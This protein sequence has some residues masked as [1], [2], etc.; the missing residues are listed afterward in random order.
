MGGIAVAVF[1]L[2]RCL[3]WGTL[4]LGLLGALVAS[5][6]ES[7]PD[8]ALFMPKPTVVASIK[9]LALLAQSIAGQDLKVVTL[10]PPNANPHA[11]AMTISD[12]QLLADASLV[13]WLGPHFERFLTKPMAQRREPQL[14]LGQ[15]AQLNWP[16]EPHQDLHLWL[17]PHNIAVALRALTRELVALE[18]LKQ[19]V[20]ERRLNKQLAILEQTA[21]DIRVQLAP[22]RDAPFAV[23]HDGYGHFV[24]AFNLTQLAAATR[25]PEQQLS[26]RR[27]YELQ[28]SLTDARCLIV[29]LNDAAGKKLARVVKLPAIEA[30]PLGQ[31]ADVTSI[32]QLLQALA[33]DFV[34]CLSASGRL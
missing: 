19:P 31:A 1:Y 20:F 26:A 34:T 13:V 17:D 2:R 22:Y 23:S 15:T 6:D 9:P 14:Q 21:A 12:R 33:D 29:E 7:L 18:P 27:L 5:A 25:L 16:G 30:D 28:Q 24:K 11:L 3:V 4:C 32:N 8:F 10:L